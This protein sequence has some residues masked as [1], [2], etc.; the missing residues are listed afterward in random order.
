MFKFFNFDDIYK[1]SFNEILNSIYVLIQQ[2]LI[3]E[4]KIKKKIEKSKNSSSIL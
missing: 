2:I 4:Y 1:F 3:I